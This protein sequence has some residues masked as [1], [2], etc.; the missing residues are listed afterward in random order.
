MI[1]Y[2]DMSNDLQPPTPY[3]T[4]YFQSNQIASSAI[5]RLSVG[6]SQIVAAICGEPLLNKFLVVLNIPSKGSPPIAGPLK[7][8]EV[9]PAIIT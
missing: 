2:M 5:A 4:Y 1:S 3:W 7:Y 8:N 9:A 6:S